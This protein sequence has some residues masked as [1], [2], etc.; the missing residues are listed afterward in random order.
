MSANM[1][2]TN[3]MKD[4]QAYLSG[5]LPEVP[6]HVVMEISAHISNRTICLVHDM[7]RDYDREYRARE[8]RRLNTMSATRGAKNNDQ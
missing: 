8:W 1:I 3:H 5:K 7:M 4:I 2:Y 6:E